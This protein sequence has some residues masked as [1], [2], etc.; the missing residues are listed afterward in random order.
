MRAR[1]FFSVILAFLSFSVKAHSV[2]EEDGYYKIEH[3]WPFEG[4]QC[5]ISLNISTDLYNYYQNDREHLVYRYHFEDKEVPPNYFSFILSE[6]D[7]HVMQAVAYEFSKNIENECDRISMALSFVQSLP[8]AFDDDSKG[9]DEYV[10]YPVETLVD[11]CGDC[12]DKVMLLSALL[13][14]MDVD[15]I[16]LSLP[17]HIAIGVHCNKVKAGHYLPFRGKRYYYLETTTECW[18]IGQIPEDYQSAEMEAI[19]VDDTPNMLVKGIRFESEPTSVFEKTSCSLQVD[20]HNLGPGKVTELWL[21]VRVVEKRKRNRL[22]AEEY[23]LLNDLQEG[24]LRT[25]TLSFKSPIRE[26]CVLQVEILGAE[27]AS[28]YYEVGLDCTRM[29][30]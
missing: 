25:E 9:V 1:L 26:H 14:E 16:L 13:Y 4:K 24:E 21:H 27:I 7:R 11:G 28:Q 17:E 19:P 6:N 5:S 2:T 10:R 15:F 18:K 22:L 8:Y 12:E 29:Q 20:L 23:Y 30:K 3:T